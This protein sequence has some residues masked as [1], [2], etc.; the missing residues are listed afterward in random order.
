MQKQKHLL[1]VSFFLSAAL[2]FFSTEE[3]ISEPERATQEQN[4]GPLPPELEPIERPALQEKEPLRSL[5]QPQEV[6][7]RAELSRKQLDTALDTGAEEEPTFQLFVFVD[8]V[9][10]SIP[11]GGMV[12]SQLCNIVRP[13]GDDGY[14]E[15]TLTESCDIFASRQDGL[16]MAFSEERWIEFQPNETEEVELLLPAERIGGLGVQISKVEDGFLINRVFEE[17]PAE[18]LGLQAGSIITEVNGAEVYDLSLYDFL[19]VMTGSVGS[20]AE[21][22]LLGDSEQSTPRIFTRRELN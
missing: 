11:K 6:A 12:L 15:L 22:K 5:R 16:F 18:Q 10:G 2:Y 3:S 8:T 20:E 17:T 1:W 7:I 13:I 4:K 9:D 21:F 14:V 19:Q